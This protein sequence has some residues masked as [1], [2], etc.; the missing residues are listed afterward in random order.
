MAGPPSSHER[1]TISVAKQ[2]M[3]AFY[4]R[5]LTDLVSNLP[6]LDDLLEDDYFLEDMDYSTTIPSEPALRMNDGFQLRT[7]CGQLPLMDLVNTDLVL[8]D[9][10]GEDGMFEAVEYTGSVPSHQILTTNADREIEADLC[11]RPPADI[12]GDLVMLDD[13]FEEDILL[14]EMDCSTFTTSHPIACPDKKRHYENDWDDDEAYFSYNSISAEN[15][16][17]TA[18]DP[19]YVRFN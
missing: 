11:K 15:S 1:K 2:L 8:D 10:F 6:M 5:P 16:W 19:A 4:E 9:R 18:E 13:L 12:V 17:L 14:N 7:K 3:A